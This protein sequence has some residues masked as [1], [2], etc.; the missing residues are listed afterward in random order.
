MGLFF[1]L[2]AAVPYGF[3]D[4][5]IQRFHDSW[6]RFLRFSA[7]AALPVGGVKRDGV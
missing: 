2:R 4:S 1:L 5:K 6:I 7:V 3:K